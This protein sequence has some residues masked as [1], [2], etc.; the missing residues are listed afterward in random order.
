VGV[1]VL[2]RIACH[3]RYANR[4]H[5]PHFPD[6]SG[7][8]GAARHHKVLCADG[9][10]RDIVHGSNV[11]F[12]SENGDERQTK[13]FVPT[14]LRTSKYSSHP[15]YTL[16]NQPAFFCLESKINQF[17]QSVTANKKQ[18]QFYFVSRRKGKIT[19]ISENKRFTLSG[20]FRQLC[21]H[22]ISSE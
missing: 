4:I 5:Q 22:K 18:F 11:C 15:A 14:L 8:K 19:N 17:Q 7:K 21:I 2:L 6:V 3:C 1:F 9:F 16:C 10:R 13:F 12:S 20:I